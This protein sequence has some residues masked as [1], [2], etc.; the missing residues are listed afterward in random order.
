MGEENYVLPV[1]LLDKPDDLVK[2]FQWI[3]ERKDEIENHL[4]TIMPGYIKSGRK[5]VEALLKLKG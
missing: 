5:A 4:K 2:A 1:Q 3:D